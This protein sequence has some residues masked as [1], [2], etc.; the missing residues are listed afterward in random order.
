MALS[1]GQFSSRYA[2]V[3]SPGIYRIGRDQIRMFMIMRSHARDCFGQIEQCRYGK[4]RDGAAPRSSIS[5]WIK[6]IRSWPLALSSPGKVVAA[7]LSGSAGALQKH[8]T[9]SYGYG[10]VS[11]A[12]P[13]GTRIQCSRS[14]GLLRP[15]DLE[16]VNAGRSRGGGSK[17]ERSVTSQCLA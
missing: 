2:R 8:A 17:P 4:S 10:A 3:T 5:G 7:F 12:S 14:G 15:S 13:T 11:N 6:G 9:L 16:N 1:S